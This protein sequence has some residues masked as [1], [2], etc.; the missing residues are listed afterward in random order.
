MLLLL[1]QRARRTDRRTGVLYELGLVLTIAI[2]GWIAF[3][4]LISTGWRRRSLTVGCMAAAAGLW[5]AGDLLLLL[6]SDPEERSLALRVNYLGICA[7]PLAFAAVGAQAARPRWWRHAGW[8]FAI[9]ALPP[10]LTYSC[11]FWDSADWFVDYAVRPPRRGPIFLANML[12]SWALAVVAWVYLAQTAMRLSKASPLRML[13]LGAG[14]GVPVLAN[15]VHIVVIPNGPDPTPLLIGFSAVLIRFAVIESGLALYLPIA[16]ADVLEQVEVG[17]LV[18]DLEG[19]VVDANRA[20][21]GLTRTLDPH[22][23]PLATL[24][25]AARNRSDV[26]VEV[27]TFPLRSSVAEVGSAALLEDRSEGRRTEQRL[28]LAARLE[29]LGFLT[30]GIA[31]EVNNPLAFIRA[32][33]S[34][35]EKLAHELSDPRVAALLSATV[36][37]LLDDAVELVGETQE[38]V[39]RIAALV[40][41]L[42]SFARNDPHDPARRTPVDLARVADAAVAMASVGMPP[43]AIRRLGCAVPLA[44]GVEGDLVQIALNLLVN[45]V[46]A[47]EN[48]VEIEVEVAPADGGVAL[49]VRDRGSGIDSESLPHLFDP[50]FTTKPPGT[51]TGLGLSLSYDLARRN[52]G[53]L[54]ASNRPDGGAA[55]SLWLPAAEGEGESGR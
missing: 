33:L 14:A 44:W 13:A 32:N 54:D 15:F 38:G 43:G 20:A 34:Q 8:V 30:A 17:V 45:A 3:D 24:L 31:H 47:S 4:L 18:A 10:L 21:R 35:L 12:Y 36:R 19:R 48:A 22:G 27:R 6:A 26:V 50:F 37:S 40:A 23:R 29:A 5:A 25:D 53:R 16:R 41:R 39:E 7:L 11:Q 49:C 1:A 42:K 52:G 55:F 46:Q 2:C 28:Q 51:G 9:A